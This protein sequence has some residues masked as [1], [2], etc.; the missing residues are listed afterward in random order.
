MF[1]GFS[2]VPRRSRELVGLKGALERTQGEEFFF[3][4]LLL[5]LCCFVCQKHN[6]PG[7]EGGGFPLD[8]FPSTSSARGFLICRTPRS[9][10]RPIPSLPTP[11][12]LSVNPLNKF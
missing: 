11:P 5:R 6:F 8:S 2:F 3:G 9:T 4:L 12:S 1:F 7:L 10:S